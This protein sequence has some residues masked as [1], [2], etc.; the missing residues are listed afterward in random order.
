MIIKSKIG[1]I[2]EYVYESKNGYDNNSVVF[3]L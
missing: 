1:Y 3:N 2:Y